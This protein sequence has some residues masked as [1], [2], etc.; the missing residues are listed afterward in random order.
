[1]RMMYLAASTDNES[2]CWVIDVNCA[3]YDNSE[4]KKCAINAFKHNEEV[5]STYLY[6]G[7]KDYRHLLNS[8]K[9]DQELIKDAA[10]DSYRLFRKLGKMIGVV[11]PITGK[12]MRFTLSE[13][14]IKFIVLA[15]IPP[16][17]MIF[18]QNLGGL[19][20]SM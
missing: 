9:E 14:I 7:L 12:G 20:G 3:G 13:D 4:A 5:I 17:K 10:D 6:K 16:K 1:M 18:F 11:I 15:I 19:F 2:N 8:D